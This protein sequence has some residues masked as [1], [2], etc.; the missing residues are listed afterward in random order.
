[1]RSEPGEP[2]RELVDRGIDL[3]VIATPTTTH[4]GIGLELGRARRALGELA[5]TGRTVEAA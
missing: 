3:C 1:M 5:T 4:E 2:T